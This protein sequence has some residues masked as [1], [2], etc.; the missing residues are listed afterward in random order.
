[1]NGRHEQ[2]F[3][4]RREAAALCLQFA[5]APHDANAPSHRFFH[6]CLDETEQHI[7]DRAILTP[8]VTKLCHVRG[9]I[10]HVSSSSVIE[11]SLI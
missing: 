3:Q 1:M 6:W 5:S 9:C 10:V 4:L 7:A 11:H 8:S 2:T